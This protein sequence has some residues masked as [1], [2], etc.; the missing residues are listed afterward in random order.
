MIWFF[1]G[2]VDCLNCTDETWSMLFANAAY[3]SLPTDHFQHDFTR[4][5]YTQPYLYAGQSSQ[6]ILKQTAENFKRLHSLLN[7]LDGIRANFQ[8]K[9]QLQNEVGCMITQL[10]PTLI[11]LLTFH[12]KPNNCAVILLLEVWLDS[13]GWTSW[14]G[15]GGYFPVILN[16]RSLFFN[17]SAR[18]LDYNHA[19][20]AS[21][22]SHTLIKVIKT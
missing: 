20:S 9:C 4:T 8:W 22:F 12:R 2:A 21:L 6:L 11:L 14:R 10:V 16:V 18:A 5:M 3:R 13:I 17:H 19:P 15:D 7:S 1:H